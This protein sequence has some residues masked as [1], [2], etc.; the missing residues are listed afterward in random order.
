MFAPVFFANIGISN[1]SFVGINGSIFLFSVLA[2]IAGLL[3]KVI[4]CGGVAK[5]FKYTW[6][7]SAIGGVGMMARGEVALIVTSTAVAS[8]LPDQFMIMTVLLILVSSISTP[9]L[10]KV[11]YGKQPP[12]HGE[13]PPKEDPIIILPDAPVEKRPK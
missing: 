11:L 8:G 1:I 3:G 12:V 5:A 10:L 9:I 4:G 13:E 7:E 6:R 2:V